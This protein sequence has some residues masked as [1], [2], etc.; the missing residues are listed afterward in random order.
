MGMYF[1]RLDECDGYVVVAD[2]A[3]EALE[4][5]KSD[6]FDRWDEVKSTAIP[7]VQEIAGDVY[8]VDLGAR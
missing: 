8:Y 4:K 7:S 2:D 1:V 6:L 3:V 5:A